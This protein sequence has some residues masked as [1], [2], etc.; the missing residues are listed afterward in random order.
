MAPHP[1]GL[2]LSPDSETLVTV[3]S[4]T[5]P[6]SVSII[7]GLGNRLR[8]TGSGRIAACMKCHIEAK[9]DRQFGLPYSRE[10][11]AATQPAKP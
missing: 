2:A 7:T 1:Y 11:L 6:F 8:V 4:G 5:A 3:N 9:Y 10:K